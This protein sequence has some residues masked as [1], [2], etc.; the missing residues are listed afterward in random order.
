[1][2]DLVFNRSSVCAAPLVR[3]DNERS[4]VDGVEGCGVACENP[5]F[6]SDEHAQMH[7]FIAIMA[8]LCLMLTFFTIVSVLLSDGES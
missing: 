8:G 2:S 4:W 1:M 5:V 6:T 3:T 7:R